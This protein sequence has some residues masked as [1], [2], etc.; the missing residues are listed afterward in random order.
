MMSID[1][2]GRDRKKGEGTLD[3]GNSWDVRLPREAH[4]LKPLKGETS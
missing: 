4:P 3:V 1:F 2:T